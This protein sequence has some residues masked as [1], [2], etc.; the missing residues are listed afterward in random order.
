[1]ATPTSPNR[2]GFSR[3]VPTSLWGR[4]LVVAVVLA[5]VAAVVVMVLN[6]RNAT[7]AALGR[8]GTRS[9]EGTPDE[10]P[11]AAVPA[12]AIEVE[13]TVTR[14]ADD[15]SAA[16]TYVVEDVQRDAVLP[17]VDEALTA[18][19]CTLR[20]RAYDDT[21]MQVIYDCEDG[22]VT[23]VTFRHIDAGTGTAIVKVGP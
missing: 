7:S 9:F 15:W 11:A 20:Q 16:V 18:D 12:A 22:S 6:G 5:I 21:T 23:T 17:T 14:R 2:A 4:L 1:M 19:G 3:L 10:L 8:E 13:G